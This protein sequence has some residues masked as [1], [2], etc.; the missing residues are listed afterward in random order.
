MKI[1][2]KLK[3]MR[4]EDVAVGEIEKLGEMEEP[5]LVESQH[6]EK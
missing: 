3:N 4:N 1:R 6:I 5:T 2:G